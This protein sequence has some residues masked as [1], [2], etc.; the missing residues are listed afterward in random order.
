[1]TSCDGTD[2]T[3]VAQTGCSIPISALK[4]A[5]FTMPW[6][7]S[8]YVKISATNIVGESL[9]TVEGNGA[10]ILTQPDP[11]ITLANNAAITDAENIGLTW[12]D[13]VEN[14]GTAIIDYTVTYD[15]GTGTYIEL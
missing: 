5:P 4:A 11:P 10:T 7:H 13:P 12:D 3:I 8:I 1:M 14:G 6:G 15:Q 2:P 9:Y